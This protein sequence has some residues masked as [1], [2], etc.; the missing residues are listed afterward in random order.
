RIAV[1]SDLHI[2][3]E[4]FA[5]EGFVEFL[6]YLEREHDEIILLGDV[7]ECY[8]PVLPWKALEEYDRFDR[9]YQDIT[10]RFRT[11]K[12]TLLSGNH[13]MVA[14]RA[15]GIPSQTERRNSGFRILLSHG[16]ENEPAYQSPLRIRLVELYM[17]LGYRLKRMG[18]PGLYRYSYRMDYKINMKDGGSAHLEA[19]RRLL[20]GGYDVVVFG[21]T[22]VE[23]HVELRG[24]G[25]YINTGDCVRRRMYA[26]LDLDRRECQLLEFPRR[27]V[28]VEREA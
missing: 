12:Y 13:D 4:D 16:H 28:P 7:F 21:H 15:R 17:W 19:A 20:R 27:R 11:S 14:L 8:F 25:T 18:F 3:A 2:G 24:G 9:Q 26:S 22:H 5:P 23:R 1:I 10:R 6:D